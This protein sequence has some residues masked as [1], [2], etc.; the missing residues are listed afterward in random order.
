L[1]GLRD[2]FINPRLWAQHSSLLEEV[3][4][5]HINQT[6]SDSFFS[7]YEDVKARN[8]A[9]LFHNLPPRVLGSLSSALSDIKVKNSAAVMLF[10]F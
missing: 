9:M 8:D 6:S 2:A 10:E 1:L 4:A 3:L 5:E 7:A